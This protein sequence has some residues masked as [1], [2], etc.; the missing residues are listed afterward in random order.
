MNAMIQTAVPLLRRRWYQFSL[1]GLLISMTLL[2][3]VL[4]L[5]VNRIILPA[6]RQRA[7]VQIVDRIGNGWVIYADS[8]TK[9]DGLTT[10]LREWLPRDCFDAVETVALCDP[11]VTDVELRS[12]G[13]LPK[14]QTL[15]VGNTQVTDA[16]LAHLSRSTHLQRLLLD[17][18]KVTDAGLTHL[19]GLTQ[20]EYLSLNFSQVTDA[21]V[22][23]L[24]TALPNCQINH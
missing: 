2:S 4:G 24:Q 22:A 21:G 5:I 15:I 11:S 17:N 23:E 18:T 6:Q 7:A 13:S 10:W 12:F 3:V 1:R 14:L 20:L 19:R 8:Q 16:G 9:E